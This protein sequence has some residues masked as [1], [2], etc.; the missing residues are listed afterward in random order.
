MPSRVLMSET[1]SAPS[2]STAQAIEAMSVTLGES[3]TI[4][5]RGHARR[6]AR[7]TAAAPSQVV[8]K[9]MPPC[10]TFGQEM[11]ISTAGM[12]GRSARRRHTSA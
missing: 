1:L 9:A 4:I 8:P 6:Q 2:A 3:F 12:R 5:V 7:V 11:F 10:L